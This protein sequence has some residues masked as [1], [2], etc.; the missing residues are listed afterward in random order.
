M[1]EPD[2]DLSTADRWFAV[3]A[4][5]RAWDL[6]ERHERSDAQ[7]RELVN[8]AHASMYHWS[9]VGQPV[10]RLRACV[11]LAAA[12]HVLGRD[13]DASHFAEEA[14]DLIETAGEEASAFDRASAHRGLAVTAAKAGH[15]G[16][17]DV[18]NEHYE[19]ELAR[20]DDENDRRVLQGLFS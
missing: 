9:R 13:E 3:E 15:Q 16:Q 7:R 14:V 20:I 11:M 17:A 12:Y 18:A 8:V 2:F 4:N 19:A 6:I 1:P 10:H 5:N